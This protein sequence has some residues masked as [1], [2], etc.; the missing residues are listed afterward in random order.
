MSLSATKARLRALT[1][2]LAMEWQETRVHWRDA[3]SDEFD[4]RYMQQLLAEVD[5]TLGTMEGL[6]KCMTKARSDCE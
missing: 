5:K 6:D 1:Q 3:K 4:M 2:Q